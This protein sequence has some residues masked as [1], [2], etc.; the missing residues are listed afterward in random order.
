MGDVHNEVKYLEG[1]NCTMMFK[2]LGALHSEVPVQWGPILRRVM[3]NEFP[4]LGVG[5]VQWGSMNYGYW[6]HEKP[7]STVNRQT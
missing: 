1:A 7:P 4:Y 3:Y 6:S 2:V 5:A